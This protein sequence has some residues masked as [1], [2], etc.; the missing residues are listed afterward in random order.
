MEDWV[1]PI[2]RARKLRAEAANAFLVWVMFNR[3]ILADRAEKAAHG[4]VDALG[5]PS[6]I[7]AFWHKL[8]SMKGPKLLGFLRYGYGGQSFHRHYKTF[9]RQLPE[10]ASHLLENYQ[11]DPRKI[12]NSQR[13]IELVRKRFEEIPG[14]GPALSRMAVLFLARN[15][16]LLG[17]KRSF[18]Q[19]DVK[20]DVHLMR[21]FR[22]CGFIRKGA[23]PIEAI[24]VARKLH[25]R[26]PPHS[27]RPPS[28]VRTG[29]AQ[30]AEI[31]KIVLL[32][33]YA[34]SLSSFPPSSWRFSPMTLYESLAKSQLCG[35]ADCERVFDLSPSAPAGP[36]RSEPP[37]IT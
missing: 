33:K 8:L 26:F 27:M 10:A 9:G 12:W 25:P 35:A 21:V 15:Y 23:K 11:G 37:S 13:D 22:R 4:F 31:A 3:S 20:P 19:M 29:V 7:G 30:A 14:I 18:P 5:D 24:E 16:G 6:E 32:G 2:S 1:R 36:C 28:T 34:P 17:G